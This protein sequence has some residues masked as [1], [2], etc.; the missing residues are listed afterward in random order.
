[1]DVCPTGIDIR[2]GVQLECI[3]CTAC[4]DAC[5]GVMEKIGKP[6]NLVTMASTKGI[7][8]GEKFHM[9][10]RRKVYSAI[11]CLLV[12]GLVFLLSVRSDIQ[13]TILRTPGMEYTESA[14]G[15]VKNIYSIKV[16]NKTFE[17][18]PVE[19]RLESVPGKIT[20]VGEALVAPGEDYA[21]GILAVEIDKKLLPKSNNPI[22]LGVY[23]EGKKLQTLKTNFMYGK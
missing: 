15:I 5:N 9:N 20:T 3:N 17:A 13:A 19:I 1:V 23:A 6:I 22:V 18:I 8:K 11:L 12:M 10:T 7:E 16:L 4:I 14:A 21:E 2:N